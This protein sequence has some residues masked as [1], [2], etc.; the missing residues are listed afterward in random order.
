MRTVVFGIGHLERGDDSAGWLVADLI[1]DDRPDV[2]VA[3]VSADPTSLLGDPRWA[4]AQRVVVV[5]AVDTGAE[6]GTVHEWA[7]DDLVGRV[8]TTLGNDHDLGVATTLT[9]ARALGRL[10]SA[11]TVFGIEAGHGHRG[12]PPSHA[13]LA[14]AEH[15]A[16]AV[17]MLVTTST[18]EEQAWPRRSS[19]VGTPTTRVM[20]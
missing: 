6:P 11:V 14:A 3:Y 7:A 8:S 9:L 5:D 13:V 16:A 18:P 20:S 10:P 1:A 17:C 15:V 2:E 19:Y 4:T 12:S